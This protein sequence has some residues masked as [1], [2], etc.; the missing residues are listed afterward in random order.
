MSEF[1]WRAARIVNE[2]V[3]GK[4]G[5]GYIGNIEPFHLEQEGIALARYSSTGLTIGRPE[6][7]LTIAGVA[8]VCFVAV[9]AG[10]GASHEFRHVCIYDRNWVV[11][12]VCH[13]LDVLDRV[14]EGNS[15]NSRCSGH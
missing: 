14:D 2:M 8:H 13:T 11:L 12:G 1:W 7:G 15:H 9:D 5:H 10:A 6:W 4:L 3:R